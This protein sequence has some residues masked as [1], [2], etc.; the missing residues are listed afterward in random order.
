VAVTEQV[1]VEFLTDYSSVDTAIETLEKSGAIDA[2]LA[3]A[4][5]QTTAEVNKQTAAIKAEA[6]ATAPLKKN[7]EDVNKATKSMTQTFMQGFQEGVIDTLKEA[8]VSAEQF[9][10]ALATGQTEASNAGES[11]RTRLRALS[12]QLAEMKLR[13]ED[14]TEEFHRLSAE[15][16]R[17]RDAMDDANKVIRNLGSDT[18]GIDNILGS[19]QAMA[20]GFQTAQ[21]FV[22]LFGDESEEL[23]KTLLKVNSAMAI[24]QGLQQ[25]QNALQKEGALS[26]LALTI[27]QKV[28][29]AQLILENAQQSTSIVVRTGAAAAQRLLNAAMAANPIGIVVVALAGLVT[30]L[31]TY[32]ASAAEARRQTS[33]LNVALGAGAEAF[34][35]RE[36]AIRQLGDA[37]VKSLENEG[38]ISSEITKLEI[39]NAKQ[40]KEAR[41]QRLR[42]LLQL[43]QNSQDADLEKRQQL[44]AEI[45]RIDDEILADRLGLNNQEF[46]LRNQLIE[47]ELK[48]R[49]AAIESQ[50]A[51]TQEGSQKQLNLQ[52]QLISVR[53]A[54]ELRADGLLE[55][56]RKAIQAKAQQE[57]IDLETAFNKR[58]IDL[59]IKNLENELIN[60]EEGSQQELALRL[61]VLQQQ[62]LSEL[63]NT[64]LSEAEKLAII[65][66]SLENQKKLRK[67]FSEAQIAEAISAQIRLNNAEIQN[68]QLGNEDRLSLQISNIA[69]S[70]QLEID[71]AN[72]N[73]T[74]I[75]E[76]IARRDAEIRDT[77]KRFLQEAVEF[78]ISLQHARDGAITRSL[79]KIAG[80][81]QE[82]IRSRLDAI[83]KLA[84]TEIEN[85]DKRLAVIEKE[86]EQKL[87][88]EQEYQLQYALLQD[89]KLQI[90]EDAEKKTTDIVKAENE[91]RRAETIRTVQTAIEVTSQL[92]GI[93]DGINQIQADKEANRINAEKERVNELRETGAIT[94]KEAIARQKRLEVEEKRARSQAA[95]RDKQVAIFKAL[96]AIPQAYLTGLAQGGPIVGAIYAALAAAQ[97]AIVIARPIPKFGKGKGK[98][99]RYEGL[100][101]VGE[102]GAELVEQ[103]GRMYVV[104]KPQ[105]VWLAK[106]DRVYN[107]A[108]TKE[109]LMPKVDKEVMNY[110]TER[111]EKPDYDK[112][113]NTIAKEIKNMPGVNLS[114]DENGF[115]LSIHKGLSRIKI[116]EKRYQ[117][118]YK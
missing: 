58:R 90:T 77:K 104:D 26:L 42:E 107:P 109:M 89:Q 85:V 6:T 20:A 13:G 10:D 32:G 34:K 108:E 23:Q 25:I 4:F 78:E 45:R 7:L 19:A 17:M 62:T 65:K 38:A 54:L 75:K 103:N 33:N 83:N 94:E 18:R 70:A 80:D 31:A 24:A 100:A 106:Q 40:L 8:G 36:A 88:S 29:N 93:L 30:L 60:V 35:E 87:I 49:Q 66:G 82:S 105:I 55:E 76:I 51:I 67:E 114:L 39:G 112:M 101:E 72:G 63:Q 14:N 99:N 98:N 79:Q 111:A 43:Q 118:K 59:R 11:L 44:A 16:G 96:L 110:K 47:E 9:A 115:N 117:S 113:A 102:T 37:S 1:I 53:T 84:A 61:Q 22:G 3:T 71:A 91:K 74:K 86:K 15:A 48:S 27:Q 12:Q 95:Q 2:K 56:Q 41:E 81:E 69:L 52:K 28:Q 57:R 73:A 21:G 92:I 64:K 5:K 68:I 116:M 46:V 97:A 50:L